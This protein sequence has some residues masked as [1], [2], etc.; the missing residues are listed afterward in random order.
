MSERDTPQE[1]KSIA[2][3]PVAAYLQTRMAAAENAALLMAA[4]LREQAQ[5]MARQ[6]DL[7]GRLQAIVEELRTA[8]QAA[9]GADATGDE[10]P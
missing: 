3:D 7:I 9:S 4:Q 5:I 8:P 6:S 1:Q 10:L 2:L